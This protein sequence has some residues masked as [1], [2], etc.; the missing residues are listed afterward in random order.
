M[1][2]KQRINNKDVY[3]D[4]KGQIVGYINHSCDPNC[5]IE[6]RVVKGYTRHI[7]YANRKIPSGT[8]LTI[9]YFTVRLGAATKGDGEM[10]DC[11]CGSE[12]CRKPKFKRPKP[13]RH[14]KTSTDCSNLRLLPVQLSKH[15]QTKKWCTCQKE[16]DGK[17]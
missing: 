8:E 16:D 9:N 14:T 1:K 5:R 10:I 3:I 12:I 17:V 15:K 2:L 13:I 6:E 4:T 11:L 7:V